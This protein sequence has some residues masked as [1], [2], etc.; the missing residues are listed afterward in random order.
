MPR[1][2]VAQS[3]GRGF[4]L[5]DAELWKGLEKPDIRE[6]VLNFCSKDVKT[7]PDDGTVTEALNVMAEEGMR[8][9]P[10]VHKFTRE[11]VGVVSERGVLKHLTLESTYLQYDEYDVLPSSSKGAIMSAMSAYAIDVSEAESIVASEYLTFSS[12][13]N[14]IVQKQIG[15]LPIV[16]E[17]LRPVCVLAEDD[18]TAQAV[19]NEAFDFTLRDFMSMSVATIE[20]TS[21]VSDVC[22]KI[23]EKGYRRIPVVDEHEKIRG[24]VTVRSLLKLFNMP[25]SKS[26]FATGRQDDVLNTPIV[27]IM[28]EK[29]VFTHVDEKIVDAE[30]K[31]REEGVDALFIKDES[32]RL[33]SIFT[34]WD[35]LRAYSG[36][37]GTRPG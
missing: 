18:L 33:E 20:D 37:L 11:V 6:G 7:V 21:R 26:K 30:K 4:V 25:E 5:T 13:L 28:N 34:M 17:K 3:M 31:R 8:M 23:I 10:I 29:I 1:V 19:Q 16:D 9:L 36:F 32:G 12:A 2:L 27:D 22:R 35:V 14:L 15:Y 24:V